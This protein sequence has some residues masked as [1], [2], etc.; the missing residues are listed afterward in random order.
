MVIGAPQWQPTGMSVST[1][2]FSF[3]MPNFTAFTP[4]IGAWMLGNGAMAPESYANSFYNS[5]I[6]LQYSNYGGDYQI[7]QVTPPPTFMA[8][9]TYNN[10]GAQITGTNVLPLGMNPQQPSVQ[11]PDV[12][13]QVENEINKNTSQNLAT[14]IEGA[15]ILNK[16]IESD[17]TKEGISQEKKDALE[18]VKTKIAEVLADAEAL[19]E[20]TDTDTKEALDK[21]KELMAKLRECQEEYQKAARI[22]DEERQENNTENG[23]TEGTEEN[24]NNNNNDNGNTNS[25]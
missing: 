10:L 8:P 11:G 6:P 20:S 7:T 14:V 18:A 5:Y 12:S 1:G 23:E 21:S 24:N 25:D 15:K 16:R 9:I 2:R 13:G 22:K 3:F 19:K 17:L 4:S